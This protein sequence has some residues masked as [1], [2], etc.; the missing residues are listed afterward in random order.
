MQKLWLKDF[1]LRINPATQQAAE[2]LLQA[3]A[4]KN[5][6]EVERHFWVTLVEDGEMAYETEAII[7]PHKIKAYTCE[8]FS[9]GRRLMCAHVAA[10]LLRLRQFL[11][12][13]QAERQKKAAEQAA[14]QPQSRLTV[15]AAL[16]NA[17]PE[18]LLAFVE[19]YA[20]R[21][22]DFALSLKTWFAGTLDIG[23]NPYLMVLDTLLPKGKLDS[24]ALRRV[25]RGLEDLFEQADAALLRG[26]HPGHA[27]ICN[28]MLQKLGGFL[29]RLDVEKRENIL[30]FYEKALEQV[31]EA[32]QAT[33]A[34]EL[35]DAQWQLLFE[36]G[37]KDELPAIFQRRVLQFLSADGMAGDKF[38]RIRQAYDQMLFPA[39]AF[40]L[41]LFLA[42][43]AA[44]DN[45]AAVLRVLRDFSELPQRLHEACLQLYYLRHWDATQAVAEHFLPQAQ[46]SVPQ[47]RELE[48]LLLYIA[49]QNRDNQRQT[50][51]L[52][53]RFLQNGS[54]EVF[55][56]LKSASEN[57][58]P[59]VRERLADELLA[60]GDQN[61]M[62]AFLAFDKDWPALAQWLE[63]QQDIQQF[64]RY[65]ALFLPENRAFV[66]EQYLNI[67]SRH[68]DEYFGQPASAFVRRQLASLLQKG[69]QAL[70]KEIGRALIERF[71]DRA[72]LPEELSE[73]FPNKRKALR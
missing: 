63:K 21:D 10:S 5:L 51:L 3:A 17:S 32:R 41:H 73:L 15:Q 67:L 22:R 36:L 55:E 34:P 38:E 6:R 42:A 1:E 12:Q 45:T 25:R 8:C 18:A 33:Q 53:Q 50:A 57:N 66:Q 68:L 49:E 43:L 48:D 47:R 65:E 44:R 52:H 24:A 60:K 4:V 26:D 58:W 29:P 62:A 11:E 35:R 54:A 64:Q 46:F 30:V 2:A 14:K 72:S 69:E 70:V 28:A 27:L 59:T 71:P 9:E 13:Q 40:L 7:T 39:P 19:H 56:K 20:R 16:R 31:L 37:L 61:K 23:T